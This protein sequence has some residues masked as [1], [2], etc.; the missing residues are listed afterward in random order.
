[1]DSNLT[2]I[3]GPPQWNSEPMFQLPSWAE[4]LVSICLSTGLLWLMHDAR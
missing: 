2:I 4:P 3:D 1:M